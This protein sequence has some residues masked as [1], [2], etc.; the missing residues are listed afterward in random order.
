MDFFVLQRVTHVNVL[1]AQVVGLSL[2]TNVVFATRLLIDTS[3]VELADSLAVGVEVQV[4]EDLEVGVQHKD[5]VVNVG[6]EGLPLPVRHTVFVSGILVKDIIYL[7]KAF[8]VSNPY[9]NTENETK[10]LKN[11]YGMLK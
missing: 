6:V 4:E 9:Y 11:P 10:V 2:R 8:V 1:L 7:T 3:W 5:G